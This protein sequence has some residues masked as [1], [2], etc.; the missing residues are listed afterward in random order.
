MSGLLDRVNSR[1]QETIT[2]FDA[3]S[4]EEFGALLGQGGG[5]TTSRAG[6][7]VG[8][9]RALGITAWYRGAR[10]LTETVASL[11]IHMYRKELN[12]TRSRR[13]KP[14]WMVRP[15]DELPWF[16]IAEHI[17][18]S[19]IH[20]GNAYA[21]KVRN[22]ANQVVGLRPV[23]PDDVSFGVTSD[24]RKVFKIKSAAGDE[25]PWTTREIFH[26]PALSN[27][28]YFGLD[29]I[30]TFADSLGIV[31]AADEYAGRYFS[32]G[33]HLGA[34]ISFP[35]E[36]DTAASDEVQKQW[37]KLH[38]GL[39]N[40]HEFGV[41][42]G[43]A[44]YH[45]IGLDPQQTQLLESRKFGV[46]EIAR[47]LG[48]VPHKLYDLERSTFSNI[49]HQA[50]EAVTDGIRPYATRLEAWMNFDQAL[51]TGSNFVEFELEGLLRGDIKTRYEAYSL[52]TGG[53]WME[54]NRPRQLENMPPLP[55]LE[56]VLRPLNYRPAN[57]PP[58]VPSE[59]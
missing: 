54:G 39:A 17:M 6:V 32:G 22:D 3:V 37:T 28:G 42:G 10:Y 49:E 51:V 4:L 23:H 11:P 45:T 2:R 31:A 1:H 18:M 27:N 19:L 8:P 58:E 56:S 57:E 55:E 20:R 35:Q 24:R 9:Q 12:G 53:P 30:R 13:G 40:A 34:Y 59:G 16:A 36:M 44:T 26:I 50:I 29:P 41:I 25:L 46:T 38:S 21:F 43:G 7:T 52:A 14:E 33:S 48:V 5:S 47:M 15:D